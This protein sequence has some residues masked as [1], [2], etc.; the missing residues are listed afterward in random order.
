MIEK[1]VY[2]SSLFS[3]WQFC[4]PLAPLPSVSRVISF[5]TL[6]PA[7]WKCAGP[8]WTFPRRL[9]LPW[10]LSISSGKMYLVVCAVEVCLHLRSGKS[11]RDSFLNISS[12]KVTV[13]E[14]VWLEKKNAPLA[15][16]LCPSCLLSQWVW[17]PEDHRALPL[18]NLE[19]LITVCLFQQ[20]I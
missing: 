11:Q 12:L 7:S 6:L 14:M 2:R 10:I 4:C 15:K 16:S 17:M 13:A 5:P 3:L 1:R 8:K 20:E 18:D 19:L 9:F